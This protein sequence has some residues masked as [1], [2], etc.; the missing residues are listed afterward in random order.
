ME[1]DYKINGNNNNWHNY[2]AAALLVRHCYILIYIAAPVWSLDMGF[3]LP[4]FVDTAF[5]LHLLRN[6]LDSFAGRCYCPFS[7]ST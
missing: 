7:L 4:T 1:F 5:Q 6:V 3:A 2:F